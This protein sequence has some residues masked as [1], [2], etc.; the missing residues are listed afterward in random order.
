M[1]NKKS[2]NIFLILTMAI[3]I[4]SLSQILCFSFI[5]NRLSKEENDNFILNPMKSYTSAGYSP[6]YIIIDGSITNNWSDTAFNNDWCHGSGKYGDPYIIENCT[7]D[8]SSSPTGCGI[9]IRNSKNVYFTIRNCSVINA[10]DQSSNAGIMLENSCNGTIIDNNCSNN[11]RNGI[12]LYSNS[13]NNTIIKNNANNNRNGIASYLNSDENFIINNTASN[14]GQQGIYLSFSYDTH[15]INNTLNDNGENGIYFGRC[16]DLIISGNKMK[17][18]GIEISPVNQA[19]DSSHSI[20]T[21]NTINEK[22]IY[23]YVDQVGLNANNLIDA[24]QVIL[25][26]CSNSYISSLNLSDGSIG[27]SM[28]HDCIDNIISNNDLSNNNRF[29]VILSDVNNNTLINNTMNY[30]RSGIYI[31]ESDGN[32]FINNTANNNELEGIFMQVSDDNTFINNTAKNNDFYGIRL[33]YLCDFNNISDNFFNENRWGMHM[34]RECNDNNISG[35]LINDNTEYGIYL[36]RDCNNNTFTNNEI[37]NNNDYGMEIDNITSECQDNI[38]FNNT[39]NNPGAIYNAIDDCSNNNWNGNWWHD[40]GILGG[41]DINDD[42]IGDSPYNITGT[43]N[44]R[45]YIPIWDDGD[46]S[47]PSVII[48]FPSNGSS[49]ETPAS[50]EINATVL[51]ALSNVESVK[52]MIN[53]SIPFNLTMIYVAGAWT[54]TWNNASKYESGEYTLTIWAIDENGNVNQTVSILIILINPDIPS[55][56]NNYMPLIIMV[57]VLVSIFGIGA[58][59]GVRYWR[60]PDDVKKF[61]QKF[62]KILE[63]K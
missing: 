16:R 46:N 47:N 53:A 34:F 36:G 14:N 20:Y 51:D 31:S 32:V 54:T 57:T 30:C 60:K 40:Y 58:S 38:I 15:I 56:P 2:L 24:G 3:G 18:N 4:S 7:I 13:V 48:E 10:G 63:K 49:F 28:I 12:Y 19:D 8:A 43:G 39:F 1:K 52:V 37:L 35:N 61:I 44:A 26:N 42:G 21:N 59:I 50:I 5:S 9:L 6:L 17:G 22:T 45:D 29:G 55:Q 25:V 62:K 11:E 23:Y 41:M 27:L 33:S